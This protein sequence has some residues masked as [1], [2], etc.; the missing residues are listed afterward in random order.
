MSSRTQPF[1][2]RGSLQTLLSLRLVEPH[3]PEFFGKFLDKIAHSPDFFRNAPIVLDAA[4]VAGLPPID[5]AAF[6]AKLREH[7]IIPVGLQNGSTEWNEA[8]VTAGL[9]ILPEGRH[10]E[11]AR[12][13]EPSAA[14]EAAPT[15]TGRASPS[16]ALV[17]RE[18]VRG[19]QQIYAP[20]GDIIVVAPVGHGAELIAGGH[21]HV[22]GSLRGRAFAGV[23]GDEQAMIFCDHLEAELLSI[24][25]IHMVNE[26]FDER[27]LKKRVKV[28]CDGE[29]LV[30]APL[31]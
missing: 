2:I 11:P 19:G 18:P 4:P 1:Q 31:P 6:V 15:P 27:L 7:R 17:V 30:V 22:Y 29:R 28:M 9:A 25:G 3:D 23:D 8:A 14:P 21:I 12:A 24:A 26:Q 20:D 10:V 16:P 5:I 13:K